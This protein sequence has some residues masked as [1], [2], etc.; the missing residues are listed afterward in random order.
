[1]PATERCE[2]GDRMAETVLQ[3]VAGCVGGDAEQ[4]GM[5]ERNQSAVAGKDVQANGEYG[6]EQDLAGD[7]EVIN[8]GHPIGQRRQRQQADGDGDDPRAHGTNL[9]NK[10]CGRTISTISM[11]RNKTK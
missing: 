11:G 10:P 9:P 7:I 8:A 1:M 6:V 2:N 5:A 4:A 3:H